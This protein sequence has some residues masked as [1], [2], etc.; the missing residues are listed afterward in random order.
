M[1]LHDKLPKWGPPVDG[2]LRGLNPR[3]LRTQLSEHRILQPAGRQ[4]RLHAAL[5]KAQGDAFRHGVAHGQVEAL[6]TAWS[7]TNKNGI[8]HINWGCLYISMNGDRLEVF[9]NNDC[10]ILH[11]KG[12]F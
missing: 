12:W 3:H 7:L 5:G 10:I 4:I 9:E 11:I 1:I 8:Y 2:K 6:A